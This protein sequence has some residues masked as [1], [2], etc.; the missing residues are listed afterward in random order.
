[1]V[2]HCLEFALTLRPEPFNLQKLL[3]DVSSPFEPLVTLFSPDFLGNPFGPM[4]YA[5]PDDHLD[6]MYYAGTSPLAALALSWRG[7]NPLTLFYWGLIR[8]GHFVGNRGERLFG[9]N[10][11]IVAWSPPFGWRG[12]GDVSG[13]FCPVRCVGAGDQP[14][15]FGWCGRNGLRRCAACTPVVRC[16]VGVDGRGFVVFGGATTANGPGNGSWKN[17]TGFMVG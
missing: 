6:F 17:I 7:R 2:A 11:F 13:D 8:T 9:T 10:C 14:V 4:G 15:G 16:W 5:G 1:M 12:R 3:L